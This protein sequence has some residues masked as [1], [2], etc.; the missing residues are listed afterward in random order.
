MALLG[1]TTLVSVANQINLY[2]YVCRKRCWGSDCDKTRCGKAPMGSK[3]R[4]SVNGQDYLIAMLDMITIR[5]L[6]RLAG[7]ALSYR[8][9]YTNSL[10]VEWIA[11]CVQEVNQKNTR[12]A[13]LSGDYKRKNLSLTDYKNEIVRTTGFNLARGKRSIHSR[14]VHCSKGYRQIRLF[15]SIV[16]SAKSDFSLNLGEKSGIAKLIELVRNSKNKD[17][18]YGKLIQIIGS[19]ETLTLAYLS[20]KTSKG[21]ENETLDGINKNYLHKVSRS[22][23]DGSYKFSPV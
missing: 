4:L 18:R 2:K 13:L 15:N 22:V 17:G 3:L 9:L 7:T 5:N 10:V 16:E 19:I 6:I 23:I 14:Q 21:V 11:S 8:L 12:T 20:V 1:Q